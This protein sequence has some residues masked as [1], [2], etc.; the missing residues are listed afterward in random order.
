V[1]QLGAGD[2]DT[3]R[4]VEWVKPIDQVEADIRR[5]GVFLLVDVRNRK[6]KFFGY[7]RDYATINRL[8]DSLKGRTDEMV[9]YLIARARAKG[10]TT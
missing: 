1:V 3:W 8:M 9:K 4:C 5:N 7:K 10:E 2:G 6:L